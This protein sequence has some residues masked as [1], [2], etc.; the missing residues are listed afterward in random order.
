M[1]S[2]WNFQFY[3]GNRGKRGRIKKKEKGWGKRCDEEK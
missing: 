3:F 2:R 1:F